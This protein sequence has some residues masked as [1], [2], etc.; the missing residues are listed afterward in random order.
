MT[1]L[2]Y[3]NPKRKESVMNLEARLNG[4]DKTK[5]CNEYEGQTKTQE[6]RV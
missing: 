3:Q 4:R 5:K 1:A 6:E 2:S